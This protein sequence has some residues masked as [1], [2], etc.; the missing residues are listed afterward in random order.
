MSTD[1][2][3]L[4]VPPRGRIPRPLTE[5]EG[6]TLRRVADTL[7]PALGDVPA[8]SAEPGFADS[9]AAALD[10]R[11]DAFE[12][13]CAALAALAATPQQDL[14]ARLRDLS[15]A[16]PETFQALSAVVAGA[17]LLTSG[18]RERI[19]YR[20]LQPDKAGL[21]DAIDDLTGLLDPVLER[22]EHAPSRWIRAD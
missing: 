2:S 19:G 14:W 7:V 4:S 13:I 5:T 12:P 17:W 20:G 8:A 15:V 21:E 22:A 1:G 16:E 6:G 9:L 18:T 11:S 10:A 3:P